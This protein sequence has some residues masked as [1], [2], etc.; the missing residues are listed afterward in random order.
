MAKWSYAELRAEV[1]K[2]IEA[3]TG[4]GPATAESV[5]KGMGRMPELQGVVDDVLVEAGWSKAEYLDRVE[6]EMEAEE[7]DTRTGDE[8]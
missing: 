2:R 7:A 8:S 1:K 6:Q 4:A 5:A 3:L